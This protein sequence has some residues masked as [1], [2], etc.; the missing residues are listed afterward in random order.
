[1]DGTATTPRPRGEKAPAGRI[2][3]REPLCPR[4]RRR[5][6]PSSEPWPAA[7]ITM[8]AQG[9]PLFYRRAQGGML[10]AA[11]LE[12]EHVRKQYTDHIQPR[13]PLCLDAADCIA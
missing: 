9:L 8:P 10:R 1:V 13:K 6:Q 3:I 12:P 7:A 5:H 2:Q 11:L 4:L